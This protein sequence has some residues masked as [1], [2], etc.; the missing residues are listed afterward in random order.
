M[1][2]VDQMYQYVHQ[3]I[4]LSLDLNCPVE[5]LSKKELKRLQKLWIFEKILNQIKEK[6][7]LYNEL[8]KTNDPFVRVDYQKLEKS[9]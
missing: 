6:N 4:S 8:L 9:N 1:E 5:T 2:N 3:G 7:Y